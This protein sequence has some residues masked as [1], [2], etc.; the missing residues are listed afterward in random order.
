M[1]K[2]V[3]AAVAASMMTAPA[4]AASGPDHRT[5]QHNQPAKAVVVKPPQASHDRHWKKGERFDRHQARNYREIDYRQ[6]RGM[7]APPRGYHWVRSGE[8]AVL[9][10]ITTGVIAAV[11]A[12]AL[13]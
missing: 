12:N 8:D 5:S 11:L 2:L 6:V 4:M 13:R 3:L 10:A 7:K 9:V 1:K